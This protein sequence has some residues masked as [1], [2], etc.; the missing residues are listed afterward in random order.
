M[1][2]PVRI[3]AHRNRSGTVSIRL[4]VALTSG[5]TDIS[6]AVTVPADDWDK[7]RQLVKPSNADHRELNNVI[8][9][10]A[11]RI[12]AHLSAY[13]NTDG[14]ALRSALKPSAEAVIS[15]HSDEIIST[16]YKYIECNRRRWAAGTEKLYMCLA[17]LLNGFDPLLRFSTLTGDTL[18]RFADY[19]TTVRHQRTTTSAQKLRHFIFFLRWANKE[20]IYHGDLHSRPLPHLRGSRFETKEVIYLT[21]DELHRI[22]TAELPPHLA[23][24]RDVFVFCCYS[25]LRY[26]DAAKLRRSDIGDTCFRAVTQKT[27]SL[28]RIELN[29]HTRTILERYADKDAPPDGLALPPVTY[30]ALHRHLKIIAKGCAIDTPQRVVYYIGNRRIEQVCPKWQLITPHVARRT[31]VVTALQLGIPQEVIMRWTGHSSFSAMRPYV[32]IVDELKA[33]QMAKFDN[34]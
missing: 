28:L 14:A 10:L 33:A 23:H 8:A 7:R 26:S 16:L 1:R 31:F 29:T 4:R 6:T 15:R 34:I 18:D 21:L 24:S 3:I 27:A 11:E 13:P 30:T 20:G 17:S 22:E 25:G 32:A 2:S 5:N 9:D 12:R 19:L